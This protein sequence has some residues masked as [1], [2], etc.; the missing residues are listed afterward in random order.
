ML[1]LLGTPPSI[2]ITA[3]KGIPPFRLKRPRSAPPE[4]LERTD[5]L[6]SLAKAV[7]KLPAIYKD[8]LKLKYVQEFSNAEIA[9]MLGISE[10]AVRKRLERARRMLEEFLGREDFSND[11]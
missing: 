10:A 11:D 7:L 3:V 6:D 4:K 9:E 8:A 2:C 1:L 5:D